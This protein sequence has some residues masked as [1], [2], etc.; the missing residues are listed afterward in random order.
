MKY[1]ERTLGDAFVF[2]DIGRGRVYDALPGQFSVTE[3]RGAGAGL[4]VLPGQWLTG[5]FS[6]AYAFDTS[7]ATH[8]GDSRVLFLLRSSF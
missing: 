8:A 5:S 3:L 2:Y 7:S 1:G 6:W 4:D